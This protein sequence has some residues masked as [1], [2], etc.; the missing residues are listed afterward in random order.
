MLNKRSLRQYLPLILATLAFFSSCKD[1]S[2]T[3]GLDVLPTEDLFTGTDEVS[4][5]KGQNYNPVK[6]QSNDASYAILGTLND[7]FTGNTEA[8][9]ITEINLGERIGSLNKSSEVREYYVDSLVLN[10]AYVKEWWIGDEDA[11]HQVSIHR[12]N[13]P[14]SMTNTY[15]SD[16]PV[17]GLYD[18]TPLASVIQSANDGLADTTWVANKY[19]NQWQFKLDDALATEV[20]NLPDSIMVDRKMFREVFGG[21]FIKSTLA[22]AESQGSLVEFSLTDALSNMRMYYSYNVIDTTDNANE[23]DTTIHTSYTFPIN[24]E[25]VRINRFSHDTQNKITFN[26][27]ETEHLVVQG[28]TG[29]MVEIDFNDVNVLNEEGEQINLF[30]YW[31]EKIKT[32]EN[33]EYYGISAVDFI[34]E[35]DTVAQY[36]D[37]AFFSPASQALRLYKKENDQYLQPKYYY[38]LTDTSKWSPAFS[39]GDY[40]KETGTY[41]F[42]MYQESF[43]MMIEKEDLRGPYY[44][45]T[46]DPASYPW[47]VLLKNSTNQETPAPKIRIKYVKIGTS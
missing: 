38:S 46:P 21:L 36:A 31:E 37:E 25:C 19:T 1:E 11:K 22:D 47:K 9:F 4:F 15:Y 8:S 26:D 17:E 34:F 42:R 32:E 2:G 7:P 18:E 41:T 10:L 45:S 5:L 13:S 23:V 20:F 16:M 6:L 30:T 44:I 24:L 35:A 12:F 28:M 14:L 27:P 39:G 3:L 29:S 43:R 33:G 40:N